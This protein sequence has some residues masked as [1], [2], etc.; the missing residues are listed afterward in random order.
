MK[1]S[2]LLISSIFITL[3]LSSQNEITE[4]FL[5]KTNDSKNNDNIY[6]FAKSIDDIIYVEDSVYRYSGDDDNW[7]LNTRS[8]VITR[9]Q[10]GNATNMIL[11]VWDLDLQKWI[12]KDTSII[13]YHNADTRNEYLIKNWNSDLQTWTDT[14]HYNKF[15]NNGNL[16]I[17]LYKN[18]DN[19]RNNF[20][21]GSKTIR[22]FDSNNNKI[23]V[24]DQNWV[25]SN[26]WVN[27]QQTFYLYNGDEKVA[28]T[29]HWDNI[30]NNWVNISQS[31]TI[32][33]NDNKIIHSLNKYWVNGTSQWINDNQTLS[34]FD[35]NGNITSWI[36]QDW[37]VIS[38]KWSNNQK[39]LHKYDNN[40]NKIE[41]FSQSWNS[42]TNEQTSASKIFYSHDNQN[43]LINKIIQDWNK[44]QDIFIDQTQTFYTYEN[45]KKTLELSQ[46]WH[47][48]E[49]IWIN[50]SKKTFTIN[51]KGYNTKILIQNWNKVASTWEDISQSIYSYNS[52]GQQTENL[53][54]NWNNNTSEWY[55]KT[56]NNS[57]YND[58]GKNTYYLFQ[59]WETFSEKLSSGRTWSYEYDD[60]DNRKHYT[61]QNWD[62]NTETWKNNTKKDYYWSPFETINTIDFSNINLTIYPNPTSKQITITGDNTIDNVLIN[63]YSLS[64][65]L[66]TSTRTNYKNTINIDYLPNDIYLLEIVIDKGSVFKKIIKE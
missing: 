20:S 15:D 1:K 8:K 58:T 41:F 43:N 32:V 24:T 52:N 64:G 48:D 29:Q 46:F 62:K 28:T 39:H 53:F 40:N 61:P 10:N 65:R 51:S 21:Y 26:G 16:L 5:T 27:S 12:N 23:H 13:S 9:D 33:N 60:L 19:V 31:I 49:T 56:Q 34:T 30:N 55:N 50:D 44:T 11:H 47:F 3:S 36:T 22:I 17:F 18:W 6:L 42:Q 7:N 54:Q 2:L 37:D 63:I 25:E 59:Q 4:T 35:S 66:I 57:S 14:V 38:N 45:N